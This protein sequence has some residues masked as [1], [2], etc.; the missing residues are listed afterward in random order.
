MNTLECDLTINPSFR[1]KPGKIWRSRNGQSDNETFSDGLA[2]LGHF[3]IGRRGA[4]EGPVETSAPKAR[5][6][7]TEFFLLLSWAGQQAQC[8]Q[9][10]E[11]ETQRAKEGAVLVKPRK[12]A[13]VHWCQREGGL[14]I[15]N[16]PTLLSQYMIL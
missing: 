9:T 13:G 12:T 1:I 2:H 16:L 10:A 7:H 15:S 6:I 3:N 14:L 4:A 8:N 11:D 5:Q